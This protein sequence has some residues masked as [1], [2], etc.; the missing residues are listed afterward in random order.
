MLHAEQA[1]VPLLLHEVEHQQAQLHRRQ[2]ELLH[3]PRHLPR[4][5]QLQYK[6]PHQHHQH[7]HQ[8]LQVGLDDLAWL[9]LQFILLL[10]WDGKDY[11]IIHFMIIVIPAGGMFGQAMAR[12]N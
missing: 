10:V 12:I 2:R 5:L 6:V 7:Q 8:H 1:G 3:H 11:E 4:T 9:N